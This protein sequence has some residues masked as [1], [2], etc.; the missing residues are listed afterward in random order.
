ME[1]YEA[2]HGGPLYRTHPDQCCHDRKIRVLHE[3]IAGMQAWASGDSP[4]PE[5]GPGAWRR[6]SDGTRSFSW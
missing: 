4:R 3:A 6:L 2:T 5:S 1:E